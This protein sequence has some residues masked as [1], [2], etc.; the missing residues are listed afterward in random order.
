MF[1]SLTHTAVMLDCK[2]HHYCDQILPPYLCQPLHL[3]SNFRKLYIYRIN[4]LFF[5]LFEFNLIA[6]TFN[7]YIQNTYWREDKGYILSL[8]YIIQFLLLNRE[9]KKQKC[10]GRVVKYGNTKAAYYF[11]SIIKVL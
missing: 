1:N 10:W 2:D 8:Y 5:L 7:C 6:N 11:Y 3:H 9:G 4:F